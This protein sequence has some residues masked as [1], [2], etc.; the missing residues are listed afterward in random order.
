VVQKSLS[1][2][3]NETL[4]FEFEIKTEPQLESQKAYIELWDSERFIDVLIGKFE[5]DLGFLWR[6]ENHELHRRWVGLTDPGGQG[7]DLDGT[8]PS[9]EGVQGYVLASATLLVE[10][11]TLKTDYDDDS[12]SSEIKDV[13]MGSSIETIDSL[14]KIHCFSGQGLP[15]MDRTGGGGEGSRC[16]PFVAVT[17]DGVLGCT[18][19]KEGTTDPKWNESLTIPVKQPKHGPKTSC[20]VRVAVMDHDE[21]LANKI[22]L[23]TK[24][25][26]FLAKSLAKVEEVTGKDI[27][28]DGATGA[29]GEAKEGALEEKNDIIGYTYIEYED[30][31][32]TDLDGKGIYEQPFWVNLYGAPSTA[33]D[34]SNLGRDKRNIAKQMNEG[35][36]EA[37]EYRGRVLI[38]ASVET[39]VSEPK[40]LCMGQLPITRRKLR[41]IA[42]ER[43]AELPFKLHVCVLEG[44]SLPKNNNKKLRVQVCHGVN[45]PICTPRRHNRVEGNKKEKTGR[46][47]WYSEL[48]MHSN[49]PDD[50]EQIPDIFINLLDEDGNRLSYIRIPVFD[51]EQKCMN[52]HDLWQL[53]N[54]L[55]FD[56]LHKAAWYGMK[57]Y[58]PACSYW[59]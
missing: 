43:P 7:P 51:K 26:G 28:G 57:R 4:S 21:N 18:Q 22:G 56:G 55:N 37:S 20:R 54:M 19:H 49:F 41:T 36:L 50:L 35:S 29:N 6:Q 15:D 5:L 58:V 2:F 11:A 13:L 3:W 53:D 27:D 39:N 30:L 16:D 40:L 46:A 14:V 59:F 44:T 42:S 8:D 32:R 47:R 10:G 25:D 33:N 52:W 48:V 1:P 9:R 23:S 12:D 34:L 24:G 45:E 38:S 17:I 31:L